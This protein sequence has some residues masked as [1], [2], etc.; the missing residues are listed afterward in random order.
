MTMTRTRRRRGAAV[1][2][3]AVVVPI[4]TLLLFGIVE[5]GYTFMVRH[6]LAMG[7]R[8]GARV[9]A[10]PGV[11]MSQITAA[12]GTAMSG[13][14]FTG[15]TVTS[16]FATLG[17]SDPIVWVDVAMTVDR[18]TF[19]GQMLGGGTVPLSARVYMHREG[20]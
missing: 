13:P 11:T 19:T 17:P 8:E 18:V 15:Y 6:A 5:V 1:V 14:G 12:V 3:F 2:E 10:Q 9:A 20:L 7:A 16:N 4:L